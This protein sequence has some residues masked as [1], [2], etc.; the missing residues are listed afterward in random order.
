MNRVGGLF[1]DPAAEQPL[2]RFYEEFTGASG[3]YPSVVFEKKGQV[4]REVLGSD[5]NRLTALLQEV[6]ER[7]RRH[8]DYTRAELHMALRELIA[9]FPVYR[10]YVRAPA[11]PVGEQDARSIAEAVAAAQEHCPSLDPELFEFLGRLLR[12]EVPGEREAE[13]VMRFQQVTGP[14]MAKGVEDTAFYNYNR[15]VALNEVGGDPGR[16]GLAP[17]AFHE[18]CAEA[19]EKWPDAMLATSTH[20]SKRSEDVRA[21]LF[22]LSEMPGEWAAA[23][24]RWAQINEGRRGALDRNTEYFFY[25]TL[26]GA[27][28]LGG[29]RALAYMEKAA[30]EAKAHTAWTR[31]DPEYE[32]ALAAFVRGALEDPAFTR[33]VEAFV[34][35]LVTPGRITSLAQ[36]LLKITAPGVPDFYQGTELWDLSLVDPDNRRPVDYAERRRLLAACEGLT[37]AEALARMDEGLPKLWLIRRALCARRSRAQAFGRGEP[38]RYRALRAEGARA[39]RVVAFSRGGQAITVVPRLVLRLKDRWEDTALALPP[40]RW[41]N[42]LTGEM[43]QGRVPV[44]ELLSQFPVALLLLQPGA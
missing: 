20:D 25:Q 21:R 12:L 26:V 22:L 38:G 5:V 37:A 44:A 8:R 15:F 31:P 35:P 3:D 34:G 14:A 23:V 2:T 10:T 42:E 30:R 41:R 33:E 17:D 11:G 4:L 43:R 18:A 16:F 28:P 40:G 9:A 29:E 7:H 39:D 1:V 19:W 24:R 36:T 27:W 6:C 13:L 32:Q